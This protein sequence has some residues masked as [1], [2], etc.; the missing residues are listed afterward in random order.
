MSETYSFV[1][2]SGVN[3]RA[4]NSGTSN[5]GTSAM[6][7]G[8][9]NAKQLYLNGNQITPGGG[10]GTIYAPFPTTNTSIPVWSGTG[11]NALL[12]TSILIDSSGTLLPSADLGNDIGSTGT[13]FNNLY[14]GYINGASYRQEVIN[15]VPAGAINGSNSTFTLG[16]SPFGNSLALY[17]NGLRMNGYANNDFTLSG[18]IIT[19]VV[20]PTSGT[21]LLADYKY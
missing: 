4:R 2:P 15:E 9:I 7:F 11:G 20:A 10:T 12:N 16:Y 13:R 14:V 6:P 17:K 1:I 18:N 19:F 8:T 21:S 5:I 3:I